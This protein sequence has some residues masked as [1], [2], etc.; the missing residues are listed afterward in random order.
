MK[1]DQIVVTTFYSFNNFSD[2]KLSEIKEWLENHAETQNVMGLVITGPEGLNGTVSGP[3]EGIETLKDQIRLWTENSELPF[4]DSY[5]EYHP[6]HEMKVKLKPEIVTLRRPDLIPHGPNAHL[7]PKSWNEMMEQEDVVVVDT[8]N[9]YETRI[10]KFKDA[11]E[12]DITDFHDF[13]KKM[14][15]LNIPKDKKLLMYCTGG[16]RCEKAILEM[17]E[18]GYD[19]VYQLEGG[20]LNY[21]KEY[22]NDKFEGEC[23]VFDYRVSVDQNLSPSQAYRLCPHCGE[24]TDHVISCTK[25]GT[26]G[27]V[28]QKCLDLGPEKETCSKNCAHHVRI[29]SRSV[30]PQKEGFRNKPRENA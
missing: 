8:R 25:C 27:H 19:Q 12:L 6:F 1:P 15:E 16:I 21:L 26:E 17:Q 20:I 14:R 29:D 3:K 7:P 4:K 2:E 5:C 18:Q 23:F 10:G 22:P 30:R 11:V 9:D 13:P 28:C 24:P